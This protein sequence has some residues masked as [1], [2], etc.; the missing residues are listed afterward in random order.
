ML[1]EKCGLYPLQVLLQTFPCLYTPCIFFTDT[2]KQQEYQDLPAYWPGLWYF[3][4]V[5]KP[6]PQHG[7][8]LQ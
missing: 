3:L 7:Q 6:Q 8:K 5:A 1:S 2:V 4:Q